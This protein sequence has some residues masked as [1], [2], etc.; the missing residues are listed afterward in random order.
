VQPMLGRSFSH[1]DAAPGSPHTVLLSYGYWQRKFGGD[2]GVLG[3]TIRVDAEP[4]QIIG[5]LPPQFRLGNTDPGLVQVFQFDRNNTRLGNFSFQSVARLRPG[6][7]I[8]QASADIA[9]L[10]PVVF[11]SF[12]PPPGGSIK[13]MQSTRMA[14]NLRML[15]QDVVGDIGN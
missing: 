4:S 2:R 3:R 8:T 13:M 7:T 12:A 11:A 14:P 10:I 1:Q 6:F 5:V 9:R 15:K